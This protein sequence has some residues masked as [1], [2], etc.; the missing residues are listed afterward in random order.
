M[1]RTQDS[2]VGL[3]YV[4]ACKALRTTKLA[5]SQAENLLDAN[6]GVGINIALVGR[7]RAAKERFAEAKARLRRMEQG[8][9]G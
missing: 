2:V 4:K 8:R 1:T 9:N 6:C 5:L 7:I 3:Q